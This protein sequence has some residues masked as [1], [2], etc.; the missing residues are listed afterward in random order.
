MCTRKIIQTELV[1]FKYFRNIYVC[2]YMYVTT[3]DE[4]RVHEVKESK[5]EHMTGF[6]GRRGMGKLYII[7]SKIEKND[8]TIWKIF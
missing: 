3:I 5:E 7:I 2:T 6:G 8:K 4:K 1:V